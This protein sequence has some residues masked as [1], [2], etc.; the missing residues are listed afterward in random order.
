[1]GMPVAKPFYDLAQSAEEFLFQSSRAS[2]SSCG[3]WV[4]RA[5]S[6]SDDGPGRV[7]MEIDSGSA[8][9]ERDGPAYC[10]GLTD[11]CRSHVR[12]GCPYGRP[13][14]ENVLQG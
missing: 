2:E 8:Q 6:L 12:C 13:Q 14:I 10:G 3:R 5:S 4:S 11:V 1:M 7:D 9:A